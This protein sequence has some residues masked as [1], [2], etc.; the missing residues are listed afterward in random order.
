MIGYVLYALFVTSIFAVLLGVVAVYKM[1]GIQAMIGVVILII[2]L[3]FRSER[4]RPMYMGDSALG[5]VV[6]KVLGD[7]PP[8]HCPRPRKTH[9][10]RPERPR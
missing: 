3:P 5:E 10:R 4:R 7:G 2:I 9:C 8:S 1:F 6:G